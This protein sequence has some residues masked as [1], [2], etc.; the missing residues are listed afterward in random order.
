LL[1]PPFN[2][3]LADERAIFLQPSNLSHPGMASR[4]TRKPHAAKLWVALIRQPGRLLNGPRGYADA[5]AAAGKGIR[6]V[7]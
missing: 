7:F 3:P 6:R 4:L 5:E 2:K 1:R